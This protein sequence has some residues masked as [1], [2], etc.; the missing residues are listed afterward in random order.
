VSDLQF[1]KLASKPMISS[2]DKVFNL[3]KM[4]GG[5]IPET[6]DYLF[7]NKQTPT[8]E[9]PSKGLTFERKDIPALIELLVEEDKKQ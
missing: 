4:E 5:K 6:K 3:A 2:P 7:I 8:G 1:H 9:Y